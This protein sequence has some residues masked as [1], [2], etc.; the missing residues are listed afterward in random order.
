MTAKMP[1]PVVLE[2]DVVR[3]EPLTP[4]HLPDLFVA[5][6]ADEEVWRYTPHLTPRTEEELAVLARGILGSDRYVGFAVV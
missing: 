4:D 2:D 6:G 3:L 1:S 5:G